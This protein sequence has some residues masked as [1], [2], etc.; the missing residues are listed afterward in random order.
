MKRMKFSAPYTS[1]H[2]RILREL[3]GETITYGIR[4][5]RPTL[6]QRPIPLCINN[7]L[8]NVHSIVDNGELVELEEEQA[9]VRVLN[10][11]HGGI[12]LSFNMG[13]DLSIRV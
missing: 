3:C 12:D 1:D 2:L 11:K 5:R 7:T 8:N 4:G 9:F 6:K 13:G 10:A